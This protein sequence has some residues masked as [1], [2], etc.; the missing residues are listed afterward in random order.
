MQDIRR[1][2]KESKDTRNMVSMAVMNQA[3][4][5]APQ[6]I[7][8]YDAT[9]FILSGTCEELLVTIKEDND[10]CKEGAPLSKVEDSKL[11]L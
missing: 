5:K 8:N 6:M 4:L 7:G 2:M 3:K 11:K 1:V 10:N 9:Q